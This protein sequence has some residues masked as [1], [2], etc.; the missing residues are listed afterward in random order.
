MCQMK[1]DDVYVRKC[2]AKHGDKVWQWRKI[3]FYIIVNFIFWFA[4]YTGYIPSIFCNEFSARMSG[5]KTMHER[6]M[7]K[8]CSDFS[9][10]LW[11]G[12]NDRNRI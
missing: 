8:P 5:Y 4:C 6:L 11:C 9:V 10:K 7:Q 12:N 3:F 2:Y 1:G